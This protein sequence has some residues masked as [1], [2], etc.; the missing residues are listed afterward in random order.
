[1]KI[2]LSRQKTECILFSSLLASKLFGLL[3]LDTAGRAACKQP[4]VITHSSG[5]G[6][7]GLGWQAG[8]VKGLSRLQAC[9]YMSPHGGRGEGAL[10]GLFSKGTNPGRLGCSVG[11]VSGS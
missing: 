3:E 6:N 1:M 8:R 9:H 10:W 2:H 4:C 5:A 11:W 7:L